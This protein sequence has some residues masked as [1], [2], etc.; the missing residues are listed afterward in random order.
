LGVPSTEELEDLVC[1]LEVMAANM[2]DAAEIVDKASKRML[3]AAEQFSDTDKVPR[4]RAA[5]E[6]L[7]SQ[8]GR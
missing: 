1:R 5:M 2:Q 7:E 8:D 4:R 6:R 3:K